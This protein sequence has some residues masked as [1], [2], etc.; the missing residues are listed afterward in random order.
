MG[1]AIENNKERIDPI[2]TTACQLLLF[3]FNLQDKGH[4]NYEKTPMQETLKAS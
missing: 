2:S 4:G 3:G 1:L